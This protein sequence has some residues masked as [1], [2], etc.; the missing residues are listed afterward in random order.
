M[1]VLT[2]WTL[3][4]LSQTNTQ[5][6]SR[7]RQLGEATAPE[8]RGDFPPCDYAIGTAYN[9]TQHDDK[10]KAPP[11]ETSE[12]RCEREGERRKFAHR[13]KTDLRIFFPGKGEYDE[14]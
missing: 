1:E 11:R 12:G 5:H 10:Q 4:R 13:S 7:A 2:T 8:N 3:W 9:S 6:H 14:I